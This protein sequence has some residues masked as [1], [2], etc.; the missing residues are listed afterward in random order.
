MASD[1]SDKSSAAPFFNVGPERAEAA[2]ALQKELMEAYQQASRAWI[3]RVQ[4]EVAL[5][6]GL[7]TKLATTRSVPEALEA[8]TNCVSQQMQMSAEDGQRLLSDCQQIT[9][10]ITKSLTKGWPTEGR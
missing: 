2:A 9:Q 5:W 3:A 1:D 6:S 7:A 10:K 8:Y 4:S